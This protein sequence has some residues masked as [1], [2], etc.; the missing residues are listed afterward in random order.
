MYEYGAY[1][2]VLSRVQLFVRTSVEQASVGLTC[3]FEH[4]AFSSLCLAMP[5]ASRLASYPHT[6]LCCA[7]L[8]DA[9]SHCVALGWDEQAE[10]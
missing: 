2:C 3:H 10:M 4:N 6:L 7:V 1:S 5:F 8:S 9:V